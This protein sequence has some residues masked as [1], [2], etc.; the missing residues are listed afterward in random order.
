MDNAALF[1]VR[2]EA[3]E[4]IKAA[5]EIQDLPK[6]KIGGY[7]YNHAVISLKTSA[8]CSKISTSNTQPMA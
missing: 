7:R 6:D 5:M 1:N 4:R 8:E 3:G 2:T